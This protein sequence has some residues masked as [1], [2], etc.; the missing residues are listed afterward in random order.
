MSTFCRPTQ[1]Q[2]KNTTS[3]AASCEYMYLMTAFQSKQPTLLLHVSQ[4]LMMAPMLHKSLYTEMHFQN[5]YNFCKFVGF[6]YI[7]TG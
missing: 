6:I 2:R 7:T 1:E 5:W 3:D 4:T